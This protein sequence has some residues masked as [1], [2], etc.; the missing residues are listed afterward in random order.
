MNTE[1]Y[2]E[3]ARKLLN[4][5][6]PGRQGNLKDKEVKK[7]AAAIKRWREKEEGEPPER[8]LIKEYGG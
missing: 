4:D 5:R 8:W 2:E 1:Q 3:D 7:F 6:F